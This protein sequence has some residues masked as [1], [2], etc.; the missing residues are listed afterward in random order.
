MGSLDSHGV[1]PLT[2][3]A[4][5]TL[6]NG[7]TIECR[8]SIL[9][10]HTL[11]SLVVMGV[12]LTQEL[13]PWI[14]ITT[15]TCGASVVKVYSTSGRLMREYG[16]GILNGPSGVAVDKFGYCIVGD[17]NNEAIYVFDPHGHHIHKI[18]LSSHVCGIAIDNKGFIYA[19]EGCKKIHKF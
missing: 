7:V 19:V 3:M 13:L 18:S 14:Q 10:E 15:Y 1:A 8:F 17:W 9:M 5:Y 2:N 16:N 11:I 6:L 4:K 12:H